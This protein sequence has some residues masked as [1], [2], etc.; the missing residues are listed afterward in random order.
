MKPMK[1]VIAALLVANALS[2]CYMQKFYVEQP[3]V[4][5]SDDKRPVVKH[6]KAQ[7]R[8]WWLFNGL[9]PLI[10]PNLNDIVKREAVGR[11]VK[12]LKITHEM[13]PLDFVLTYGLMAGWVT[14]VT[15]IYPNK[16]DIIFPSAIAVVLAFPRFATITLEGDVVNAKPKGPAN[17]Y[18]DDED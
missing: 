8:S 17:E 13:T 9:V 16:A 14:G 6:F 1:K 2:G 7:E 18:T 3:D 10:Q 5:M 4:S 11:P 15:S 12:N